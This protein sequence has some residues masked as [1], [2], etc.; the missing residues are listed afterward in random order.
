MVP[1]V[2]PA[3]IDRYTR[4]MRTNINDKLFFAE[5]LDADVLVDYGCADGSLLRELSVR[6]P[7]MQL[8]GFDASHDMILKANSMGTRALF[9]GDVGA[10]LE[11]LRRY[12]VGKRV[13]LLASSVLHEVYAYDDPEGNDA[14]EFWKLVSNSLF[15]AFVLRDMCLDDRTRMELTPNVVYNAI[16]DHADHEQLKS[17]ESRWGS[18][19][20][21]PH[22]LHFMLKSPWR[23]NW[24]REL[25]E[26]YTKVGLEDTLR[27]LSNRGYRIDS[28]WHGVLPAVKD[29]VALEF[30]TYVPA[31]TH[32]KLIAYR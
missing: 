11:H 22:A 6:R 30:G 18:I 29:R 2:E 4:A 12:C 5:D 9:F 26:D 8:V 1:H 15:S 23:A 17:F 27:R 16:V 7:D 28:V 20:S 25:Q 19:Y 10:M 14:H 21:A 24:E 31:P 13:A 32:V 3:Y